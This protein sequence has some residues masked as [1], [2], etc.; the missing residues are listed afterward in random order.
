MRGK[1]YHGRR[2][3]WKRPMQECKLRKDR[4]WCDKKTGRADS[5]ATQKTVASLASQSS[6]RGEGGLEKGKDKELI[7][8]KF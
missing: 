2:V 1:V 6:K 7:L 5:Q 8:G 4:Y 3:C